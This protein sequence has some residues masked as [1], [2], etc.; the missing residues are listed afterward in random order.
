MT[1][2]KFQGDGDGDGD[3]TDRSGHVPDWVKS[4]LKSDLLDNAC[5]LL[6][7]AAGY[8]RVTS[9]GSVS[10]PTASQSKDHGFNAKLRAELD[11]IVKSKDTMIGE[12][13]TTQ[14]IDSGTGLLDTLEEDW[15][16]LSA[17]GIQV[18][19][20]TYED[21]EPYFLLSEL[22]STEAHIA[23]PRRR[24]W[25]PA[26][27]RVDQPS[28]KLQKR[29]LRDLGKHAAAIAAPI[30]MAPTT[31]W[32]GT[33]AIFE[34]M[35]AAH[36]ALVKHWISV[37]Q[38]GLCDHYDTKISLGKVS[39]ARS[40]NVTCTVYSSVSFGPA[41]YWKSVKLQWRAG[42]VLENPVPR[43]RKVVFHDELSQCPS[44]PPV[45]VC[46]LLQVEASS[47]VVEIVSGTLAVKSDSD[48]AK[49]ETPNTCSPALFSHWT[50]DKLPEKILALKLRQ[51]LSLALILAYAYLH[52]SGSALWPRH[53]T[54]NEV[55]HYIDS[56][57]TPEATLQ[58][59]F[60]LTPHASDTKQKALA[61]FI[62]KS[63]PSLPI[64]GTMLL[65]LISGKKV[66]WDT[67]EEQIKLAKEEPFAKALIGAVDA[68]LDAQELKQDGETD[69]LGDKAREVF[70][71][72]VV[73]PLQS[74]L[75][76]GFGLTFDALFGFRHNEA[77]GDKV[78]ADS[79]SH[80]HTKHQY[81]HNPQHGKPMPSDMAL[82]PS[83]QWLA[84][85]QIQTRPYFSQRNSPSSPVRIAVIDTG[86][87]LSAD[88]HAL[89]YERIAECRSWVTAGATDPTSADGHIFAADEDEDG[90]G[91]HITSTILDITAEAESYIYVARVVRLR[92]QAGTMQPE[93]E[94]AI[95]K[96]IEYAV[97]TWGVSII[98]LSLGT[99]H[100]VSRIERAIES[101]QAKK[102]LIFASASNFG[103][104]QGRSWPAKRRDVFCVHGTD[105]LG[106]SYE[107]NP[108]ALP[109]ESNFAVLGVDV[110]AE[111]LPNSNGNTQLMR[112]TGTSFATPIAAGIAALVISLMRNWQEAYVHWR[113]EQAQR[114]GQ[115]GSYES[116]RQS[117]AHKLARLQSVGDMMRIF[118]L[119]H[120]PRGLYHYIVPAK[121]F[122][123]VL[124]QDRV[125][126]IRKILRELD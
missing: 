26:R 6:R 95:A 105:A 78:K 62:N 81:R 103:G 89:H 33:K 84:A 5:R 55:W 124:P 69:A 20:T 74:A 7:E 67:Y 15:I 34:A 73:L 110:Q 16:D 11:I 31:E 30:E 104:N 94:E 101:A 126:L 119:M 71:Q 122:E 98:S 49:A 80:T 28:W 109:G 91:T 70:L 92:D 117:Y 64:L 13:L 44:S 86:L 32:G 29:L 43:K 52:L 108:S 114:H 76:V 82:H 123:A 60:S 99:S 106:N 45:K 121:L 3:G 90:H 97:E 57:H 47:A 24:T 35:T 46:E 63:S 37:C 88:S 38:C 79:T 14:Q 112:Q 39:N 85:V 8:C 61:S 42:G 100:V 58:P 66:S 87:K 50:T 115:R 12:T 107:R 22:V 27:L 59:L 113:V 77:T 19:E 56:Q 40:A 75:E 118:M 65:A 1:K 51:R 4:E 102:V 72:K 48:V 25:L 36:E 83:D 96:A 10:L 18:D 54:S 17:D 116:E 93:T 41:V 68:C 53:Q 2:R 125:L 9:D 23:S 111:W 120:E 21:A